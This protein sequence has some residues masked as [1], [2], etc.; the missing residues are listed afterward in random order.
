MFQFNHNKKPIVENSM[1]VSASVFVRNNL[2]G[3]SE[4]YKTKFGTPVDLKD[5]TS[6][7]RFLD[8][9]EEKVTWNLKQERNGQVEYSEPNKVKM[10]YT[11]SNLGKGFIV[12]FICNGCGRKARSLYIPPNSP[13][14]LCRVCHRLNY[15]KQNKTRDKLVSRLLANPDLRLRY[16]NSGSHKL[17]LA[18]IEA[19][20]IVNRGLD[21]V[22]NRVDKLFPKEE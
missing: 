1:E 16:L 8:L 6:L 21:E 5:E 17:T 20:W 10:T 12:W 19:Q 4:P 13:V 14:S 11:K 9:I 18:A 22:K 15:E 2:I 3:L 7:R